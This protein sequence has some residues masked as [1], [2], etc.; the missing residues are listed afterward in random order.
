MS[1]AQIHIDK[2]LNN[3]SIRLLMI[4]YML[5]IVNVDNYIE[6]V[7]TFFVILPTDN[8]RFA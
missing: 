3:L 4:A 5:I 6:N 2:M 8:R 1:L 7:S